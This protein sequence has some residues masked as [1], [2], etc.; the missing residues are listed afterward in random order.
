VLLVVRP[1]GARRDSPLKLG[2]SAPE[3]LAE[4]NVL[5]E[6]RLRAGTTNNAN[7]KEKLRKWL[8]PIGFFGRLATYAALLFALCQYAPKD[9][10]QT[11]FANLTLADVFNT[12]LFVYIGFLLIRS[13]LN[14][15]Q[16]EESPDFWV[17]RHYH[18]RWRTLRDFLSS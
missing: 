6:S 13:L 4:T 18:F 15:P 11:P 8:R 7:N 9:I 2:P 16:S 14:P 1:L 3:Q 10:S 12:A 17:G 5:H